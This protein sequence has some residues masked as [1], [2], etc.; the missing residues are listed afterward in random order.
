VCVRETGSTCSGF[1]GGFLQ[2]VQ[3]GL[4]LRPREVADTLVQPEGGLGVRPLVC[5]VG[6]TQM[7][8]RRRLHHGVPVHPGDFDHCDLTPG[9]GKGFWRGERGGG[10]GS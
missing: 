5:A 4:V 1:G 6:P 10:K 7:A 8:R 3:V 2:P 9:S